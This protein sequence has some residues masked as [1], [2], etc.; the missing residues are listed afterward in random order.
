MKYLAHTA[1]WQFLGLMS[2]VLAWI[3]IVATTG[4]NDWRLWFVSD[5][6]VVSSGVA[7]VGIWRACFYS[8]AL[9]AIENCRSI[10]LSDSFAPAEIPAAQVLMVL[11]LFCG[12]LGNISAAAAMRMVYFSMKDRR[13]IRTLFRL[14]GGLY[15]LTG[16]CSS[17][18]LLWNMNS[19]LTN[20]TIHFPPDFHLP[21]SPA[22]QH[23]GPAIIVGVFASVLTLVSGLLFLC[24]RYAWEALGS[25]A[26]EDLGEPETRLEQ[27]SGL[28]K[29]DQQGGDNPAFHREDHP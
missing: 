7:W 24:Y 18:P 14:A 2:G 12:L 8:H 4:L 3:L 17:V 29:G 6:S 25:D 15:L 26:P 20:R 27:K 22:H 13:N 19:V 11:A 21:A 1:H 10:G 16:S 23:V 5:M 28:P 9:P